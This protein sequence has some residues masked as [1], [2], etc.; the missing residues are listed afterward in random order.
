[1]SAAGVRQNEDKSRPQPNV[2]RT[3]GRGDVIKD[4][5]NEITTLSQEKNG[6]A[7]SEVAKTLRIKTK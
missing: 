4:R 6:M 1:M 7:T 2:A 3:D 5:G